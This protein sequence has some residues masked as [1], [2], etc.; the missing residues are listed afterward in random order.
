[1]QANGNAPIK[2]KVGSRYIDLMNTVV[3]IKKVTKTGWFISDQ[4]S[5]REDGT[6]Y[7]GAA[8]NLYKEIEDTKDVDSSIHDILNSN[9]DKFVNYIGSLRDR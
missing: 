5:Y 9:A 3:K 4:S 1:M 7:H 8:L 2:V 6:C